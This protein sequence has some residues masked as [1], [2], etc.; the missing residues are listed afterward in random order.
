MP[1][2]PHTT[3]GAVAPLRGKSVVV[4]RAVE[5]ASSLTG[6]LAALG[7]EV[8]VMPVI[9]VTAPADW[10]SADREIER[11]DDYDWIVLTST[12]G[13]DALDRRMH[14]HGLRLADLSGKRVAAVGSATAVRLR[15]LGVEPSIVPVRFRAEGLVDALREI[16]AAAGPKVLIPRAE[17]AREVLPD[18]LRALG[19]EVEVTPVYRVVTVPPPA[20]VLDRLAAGTVDAVV[21]ASGGT[22]RRFAEVLADAGMDAA[23]VLVG[24]VVASIG[25]V[26]TDALHA[27]GIAVDAQAAT[28]TSAALV[29]ALVARLGAAS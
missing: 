14:Q 20:D 8:L 28:S 25:P 5:Q 21:F 15:E 16:G 18:E 7:A 27:L 6:P 24:P 3:F 17:E 26:T 13:V 11:L 4:T 19:F 10:A 1:D 22:A 2:L 9:A 29:E 23:E 12:N